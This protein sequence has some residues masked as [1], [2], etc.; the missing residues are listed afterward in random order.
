MRYGIPCVVCGVE[1][2]LVLAYDDFNLSRLACFCID[3]VYQNAILSV[4]CKRFILLFAVSPL[5]LFVMALAVVFPHA[6]IMGSES[7]L[8]DEAYDALHEQAKWRERRIIQNNDGG[9]VRVPRAPMTT[10]EDMLAIRATPLVGTQVDTIVYDTAAGTFGM[11]AHDTVEAEPFLVTE[12]RYRYN[13]LPGF[14]EQGTD[15]LQIMVDFAHEEAIEIFWGFRMN[16]T[17]DASNELLRPQLKKDHPEWLISASGP[18]RHG[19]STAV[20]YGQAE[21]REL[22]FRYVEEV[23]LNYDVDGV[24]LDFWRHPVFFSTVA[25]GAVAGDTERNQMTD[26]IR[27]IR[28]RTLEIGKERGKPLLL[29][30]RVPDSLEYCRDIGLDVELWLEEGLIDMLSTTGYFRLNPWE[31]SIDLGSQYGVP[32]Y[33]ALSESRVPT[34]DDPYSDRRSIESYRARAANLW[35]VGADGVYMFNAFN[36]RLSYWNEMG[37]PDTLVGL[38]K[39]YY[40][41][42]RGQGVGAARYVSSGKEYSSLTH[43]TPG[44]PVSLESAESSDFSI[45]VSEDFPAAM[46]LGKTPKVTLRISV[47]GIADAAVLSVSI[48]GNA[49]DGARMDKGWLSF[50]VPYAYLEQGENIVSVLSTKSTGLDRLE[51]DF[52][53]PSGRDVGITQLTVRAD[54]DEGA[55]V[56][57]AEAEGVGGVSPG[58]LSIRTVYGIGQ[59]EV[60]PGFKVVGKYIYPES[61]VDPGY[62]FGKADEEGS[63]YSVSVRLPI[64]MGNPGLYP[65]RIIATTRPLDLPFARDDCFF[66][67]ALNDEGK[68]YFPAQVRDLH[69]D[70]VYESLSDSQTET[71]E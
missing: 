60:P 41:S 64:P 26:L 42:V 23:A 30:V 52:S 44:D 47:V 51:F 54:N 37:S 62:L 34:G 45:Y 43:L 19:G 68:L 3:L 7:A 63:A 55:L 29:A 61:W 39:R 5:A 49:L 9:E 18:P 13:A 32:V 40:I 1:F 27:R 65:L 58:S 33:P 4:M 57:D 6:G 38:D 67:F 71:A 25:H 10:A 24:H 14:I 31:Y 28:E 50:D 21:I 15:P 36:P 48:N 46:Q 69:I 70:V 8:T 35:Q 12:G 59:D 17:H 22:A 11:F 16:D 66:T 20:D 56:I 2:L 53:P